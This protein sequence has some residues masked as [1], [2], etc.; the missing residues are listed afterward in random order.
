M[1][2][3]TLGPLSLP[4][5]PISLLLSVWLASWVAGHMRRRAGADAS[6]AEATLLGAAGA[7]LLAA[8]LAY[9]GQHADL[10]TAAP[11][12]MLD[13]RDGGWHLP[14]GLAAGLV[15]LAVGLV[16]H[17]DLRRPLG[18]GVLAGG[19]SWGSV[20]AWQAHSQAAELPGLALTPL[21][22]DGA[23]APV[24]LRMLAQGQPTVVNLWASWC[25]P[26]RQEMP[27][28][29][30]AQQREHA[31]SIPR[32]RFL[33]V[34]QGESASAVRAYLTDQGLS[35]QDVWLDPAMRLGP[36]VGS[37]GLPTTLFLDASGRQVDTHVGVLSAVALEARLRALRGP[38]PTSP[39]RTPP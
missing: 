32:V 4:L 9:L 29:A 2:S 13:L 30:V 11:L 16:R 36:A 31:R 34:N 20:L 27:V 37:R 38:P 24:A 22:A 5:R 25:G 3:I 10:Y 35:L 1:L 7:G 39:A 8:R 18:L 14:T 28:L 26:C 19:M 23:G 33:F 21:S 15:A 17:P 6:R 12:S